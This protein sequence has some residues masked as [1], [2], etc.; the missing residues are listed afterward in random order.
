MAPTE[1]E[2]FEL[3][4]APLQVT[5]D[6]QALSFGMVS[7]VT[8]EQYVLTGGAVYVVEP[9]YAAGVPV[10]PI[11]L[12]RRR[13]F[14]DG[15]VPARLELPEFT[16]TRGEAGWVMTPARDGLSQDDL[17]RFVDDWRLAAAT[18][19]TPATVSAALATVRIEFK[20]GAAVTLE[21]VQREPAL[22]LRHRG[23][24][25]EYTFAAASARRLLTAPGAAP[26]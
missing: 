4:P 18:R 22:V 12:V 15:A 6:A 21:V 1:L 20:D 11:E 10:D 23:F 17:N 7:P 19:V 3:E 26:H 13:L 24:R 14:A 25:I 2:R 9:R 16:L 8:R 5:F